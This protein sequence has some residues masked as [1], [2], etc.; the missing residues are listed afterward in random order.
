MSAVG[1]VDYFAPIGLLTLA[2]TH[3]LPMHLPISMPVCPPMPVSVPDLGLCPPNNLQLCV[4]N[5][6]S[7]QHL[8][9]DTSDETDLIVLRR[10]DAF[11]AKDLI[12]QMM[13]QLIG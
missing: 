3:H 13:C 11:V 6:H 4:L 8:R 2:L 5:P 12:D 7:N 9:N 1:P 10:A